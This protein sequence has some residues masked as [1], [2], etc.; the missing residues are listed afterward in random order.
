MGEVKIGDK[1]AVGVTVS[2]KDFKEVSLLFDK[3]SGLPVKSE[4]RLMEP[5][6]DNE[7]TIECRYSDYKD[8]NGVKLCGTITVQMSGE[9]HEFKVDFSEL[10]ATN[11]LPDDRFD[12]P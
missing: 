7:T 2:H 11:K 4:I 8:F 10:K 3:D 1:T 9:N 6:R 12:M 5:R